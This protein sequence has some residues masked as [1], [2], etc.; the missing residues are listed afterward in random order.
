MPTGGIRPPPQRRPARS[1]TLARSPSTI[2]REIGSNGGSRCY[3]AEAADKRA[4]RTARRPKQCK[5]SIYGQLRQAVAAKLKQHW[6]PERIAGWLKLTQP[7]NEAAQV[8]HEAIY[9]SLY[10][11]VRGVLKKE[12]IQ[13]LR[14]PRPIR[15]L[16]HATQKLDHILNAVSIR[17][18]PASVEDRAVPGHWEGDLLCGAN[19]SQIVTLVERHSRYVMLARVPSRTSKTVVDALIKQARRLPSELYRS[20]TWDR[21]SELADP[22]RLTMETDIA[23]YFCDR[24]RPWQRG[25]NENT[26]GLL[27]QYLPKGLNLAPLSQAELNKVARQ[28]NQRPRKTLDFQ[29]PAERFAE[30]VASTD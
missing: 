5:L 27:R 9:R 4:W 18:R 20:L 7:G 16:R 3:C 11:Q 2:T 14:A 30:T 25:S 13:H 12:L 29:T 28:L 23:V 10:I 24:Q 1:L 21:G 26:D 6:S 8:S 15:R 22:Q 19:N 17:E